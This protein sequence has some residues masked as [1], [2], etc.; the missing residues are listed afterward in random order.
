MVFPKVT[1]IGTGTWDDP[2]VGISMDETFL[3]SDIACHPTAYDPYGDEG[4]E[5][6]GELFSIGDFDSFEWKTA[7]SGQVQGE[8][9]R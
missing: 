1:P 8:P 6:E 2:E 9:A 5:V 7:S 4:D 3:H